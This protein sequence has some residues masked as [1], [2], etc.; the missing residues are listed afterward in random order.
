MEQNLLQTARAA[1][2]NEVLTSLAKSGQESENDLSAGLELLLPLALHTLIGRAEKPYG[3]EVLWKLSREAY[4]A[5]VLEALALPGQNGWQQRS[6]NLMRDLIGD[7]YQAMIAERAAQAGIS[8][9]T[10]SQLLS[11]STTALLGIAG[12]YAQENSL[13]PAMLAAWLVREKDSVR[14]ALLSARQVVPAA[15]GYDSPARPSLAPPDYTMLPEPM[16][17]VPARMRPAAGEAY[18]SAPAASGAGSGGLR[19]QWGLLLLVAVLLGY[20]FGHERPASRPAGAAAAVASLAP[21][22]TSELGAKAPATPA[23]GRYDVA[24]GNYIY[25]TGQPI[26]LRLGDGTTQKVGANSTENRLFTFL[27]DPAIE[28]DSVNRTKGWIN[29]DR[30]YF[31]PGA[32]TL[33]DESFQQLRNVASILKTFPASVVKIGGYTDS[34][35]NPLK[36][37]QLSEE[38]AK[39]AML[40]M[41]GMGV[42]MNRI[43]AKGYG[44]KYFIT[45]NTT[46][47]GRALNRRIS[48]RVIRK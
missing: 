11:L 29:F 1:F 18:F 48:I 3:P 24:S 19:W 45:P 15:G 9:A 36:N 43:Q 39:T 30:V 8:A 25:D 40:A 37:F 42:D 20:L 46:P 35:G 21:V 28:V 5:S 27:A 7:S 12:D 32:T 33:T 13:E 16:P 41:A 31:D 34:T 26:I 22:A 17:E 44:G 38:R 10:A 4:G 47:E 14:R 6:D 2:T 23:P